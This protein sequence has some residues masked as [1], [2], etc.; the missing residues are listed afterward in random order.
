MTG[1]FIYLSLGS[2]LGNR[3]QN[4]ETA[5][6]LIGNQLGSI[7]SVSQVYESTPWGY[8]SENLYYNC[9]LSVTTSLDP[10]PLLDRIKSIELILGRVREGQGYADRLIDIDLLL[11]GNKVLD[12]PRLE[13]PHPKM[14]ER[15]FVLVPLAEIA[16]DLVHPSNGLAIRELLEQCK[17]PGNVMPV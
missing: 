15:R 9:C 11:Y 4:L 5:E 14:N 13:V 16:A 3:L 6:R 7:G 8:S 17:D 10:I 12:H 2:N 1:N